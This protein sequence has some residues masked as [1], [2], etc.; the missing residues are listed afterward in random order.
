MNQLSCFG[1][2][3]QTTKACAAT[4]QDGQTRSVYFT[5][6][7]CTLVLS[8]TIVFFYAIAQATEDPFLWWR[9]LYGWVY[10]QFKDR[11]G[12][13]NNPVSNTHLIFLQ[14]LTMK[15]FTFS[16]NSFCFAGPTQRFSNRMDVHDGHFNDACFDT[17][18]GG[19]IH[20]FSRGFEKVGTDSQTHDR[21]WFAIHAD[22]GF[23]QHS[24]QRTNQHKRTCCFGIFGSPIVFQFNA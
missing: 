13:G 8:Q 16:F 7:S 20:A 9:K 15:S 14:N 10:T 19:R 18:D 22:C 12:P 23:R 17:D 3:K 5:K 21:M 6:R 11:R 24:F 4:P 2:H 1:V